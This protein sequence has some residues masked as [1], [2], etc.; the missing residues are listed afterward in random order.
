MKLIRPLLL[1]TS[2]AIATGLTALFSGSSS[3][4][5]RAT[6]ATNA[7]ALLA[8]PKTGDFKLK[9]VGAMAFGPGG[10]LLI[11]EPRQGSIVAVQTGDTGP[12]QKL[13]HKV[14]NIPAL[15]A[16][17]LGTTAENVVIANLAVNPASGRI[18]L[19][20]SRKPDGAA[21][22]VTIDAEGK[23]S[24]LSS[25]SLPWTRVALPGS[26]ATKVT[27]ITDLAV[28][29][30]RVIV[31]GSCNEEF[32]SKIFSLALPLADEATADVFSAETYHVSHRK[33]ETKAPISAFIPYDEGGKHF[34]VGAFACT[35][36]A[37]FALDDLQSGSQVK[38]VSM[39]ELGAGNR[40]LDMF[41]YAKG[42]K[43][44]LVVHT[45]RFHK[46][47]FGSSAYWGARVDM[48]LLKG[49]KTNENAVRRD[50]KQPKDPAG[51]EIVDALFGAVQVGKL[52]ND[53]AVVLRDSN[54]ALGLEVVQLP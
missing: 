6:P 11:A 17:G 35:P 19:S 40:P 33:W 27:N 39:V 5:L 53:E 25:T 30:N 24:A 12:L 26:T 36:V 34:I 50:T 54:G 49:D 13:S 31:A 37:K 4:A 14:E 28:A 7:T 9:S 46:P 22:I 41:E 18:Y 44:W 32:A 29:G 3:P 21:A 2:A 15:I 38:G 42:G 48:D 51:I 16:G 52:A 23:L 45:Q 43:R 20:V 1:G 10:L 47:L 8:S